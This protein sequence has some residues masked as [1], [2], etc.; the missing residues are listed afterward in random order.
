MQIIDAHTH[1]FPD[2][3]AERAIS[4]LAR[5]GGISPYLSGTVDALT[6][7]MQEAGVAVSMVLP[8]ATS[9]RQVHTINVLSAQMNG[10]R[11]LFY[12]GAIHPDT[13]NV[14]EE[15][16]FIRDAGLFGIKLHPDY[17]GTFFDDERY[18]RIMEQAARRG[19][20]TVTHAGLDIAYPDCIH[21]TADHILHVLEDL[22]GVIEDRL[23]L[24]HMG[25]YADTDEIL[26]RVAGKPVYMDTAFVLDE[27]PERCL[28]IIRRHSASRVLFATD[29]PWKPQ[30]EYVQRI[31]SLPLSEKEKE[32]ICWG[33]AARILHLE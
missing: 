11:G 32:Q 2:R 15:L 17:Q 22:K 7:S 16:D 6:A 12:A 3:L 9:P 25:S 20:M 10:K 33:N 29:S 24:A 23:I 27:Y 13:E 31:L 19:L 14:E 21:C 30:K 28:K 26:E 1:T 8:V 4:V 5:Q 18:L